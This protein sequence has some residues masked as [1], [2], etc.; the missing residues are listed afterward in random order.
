MGSDVR[1]GPRAPDGG[2][3]D[4]FRDGGQEAEGGPTVPSPTPLRCCAEP[5]S[6]DAA[7]HRSGL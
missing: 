1:V 4:R 3:G 5:V 2:S 6:P 7:W